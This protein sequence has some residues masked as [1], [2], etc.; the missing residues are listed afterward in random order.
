MKKGIYYIET[1]C[2]EYSRKIDGYFFSEDDARK[3]IKNCSNHYG[4]KGGGRIYFIEFGLN[5][6][7]VLIL[8]NNW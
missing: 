5:K 8:N 4:H 2:T 7:P 1:D 6:Q 3:A